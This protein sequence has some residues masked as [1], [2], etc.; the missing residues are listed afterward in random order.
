[1][2]RT[3]EFLKQKRESTNL[4][5]S[6]VA[7]ATKINPKILT[8]IENG[9]EGNLP[10]KTFLKG[11]I[12]SYAIYLK[13]DPDEAMRIY[14][15]EQ[16]PQQP[17]RI[18]EIH[19]QDQT[20]T[21]NSRRQVGTEESTA[22]LRTAGVV[23]III[24]IGMIIGV[25]ELIEKYQREKVVE[26]AENIK[27]NP[28]PS[29]TEGTEPPATEETA[30][31]TTT[32]ETTT[33]ATEKKEAA[34][35]PAPAAPAA[36]TTPPPAPEP[37]VDAPPVPAHKVTPSAL[38]AVKPADIFPFAPAILLHP[39]AGQPAKPAE[40]KPEVKP[41]E[42]KPVAATTP[43]TGE[44][45]ATPPAA[46][47]TETPAATTTPP[48]ATNQAA[49]STPPAGN[50]RLAIKP[51]KHEVILEAMDKVDVKLQIKGETKRVSLAP[52][53]VHTILAEDALVLDLSD[54]GAVNI[55][56]NGRDQGPPGDLGKPKQ[57]KIP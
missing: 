53:Q 41:P 2:K 38:A 1:M 55:I 14:Q 13:M 28:L 29:T 11:F 8:A 16:G 52:T 47:T 21:S 34:P 4:S 9:D 51:A 12:R 57:V 44:T 18:H 20:G 33:A 45:A 56:L 46:N 3:G 6:E 32:E 43:P 24:L 54:G 36:P 25:R 48:A 27:V 35:L 10:A 30:E 23:L 50:Q 15:E 42:P 31:T 40:P 19:R 5:I 22:G 49:T 26:A 39:P 17:E 37:V 7:L